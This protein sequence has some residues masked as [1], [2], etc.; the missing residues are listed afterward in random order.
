MSVLLY[1][2]RINQPPYFADV[3]ILL[4]N[5]LHY[6]WGA[7]TVAIDILNNARCKPEQKE[8]GA[9]CRNLLGLASEDYFDEYNLSWQFSLTNYALEAVQSALRKFCSKQSMFNKYCKKKHVRK[10]IAWWNCYVQKC[11]IVTRPQIMYTD[12]DVMYGSVTSLS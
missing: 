9:C 2:T 11:I 12:V 6:H 3:Y 4:W 10:F 7:P 1:Y 5:Q 8:V